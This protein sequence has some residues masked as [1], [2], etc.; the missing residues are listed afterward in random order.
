MPRLH[1]VER[2][3][4]DAIA[5]ACP[6]VYRRWF[7][8]W[9]DCDRQRRENVASKDYAPR[10]RERC[11]AWYIMSDA[12][13]ESGFLHL[14]SLMRTM[15]TV[16]PML[17]R[18]TMHQREV[19]RQEQLAPRNSRGRRTGQTIGSYVPNAFD[20]A[21][22][23]RDRACIEM[24]DVLLTRPRLLMA[25]V[26]LTERR[27]VSAG[28]APLTEYT[29]YKYVSY[30]RGTIGTWNAMPL[31][32]L[33][34][35]RAYETN[36]RD[37]RVPITVKCINGCEYAGTYYFTAGDYCRL[38]MIQRDKSRV[39][40]GLWDF[41]CPMLKDGNPVQFPDEITTAPEQPIAALQ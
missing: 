12:L 37:G 13:D 11:Y 25:Y 30:K 40:Q 17:M 21:F 41:D 19:R 38:K 34:S 32:T 35:G 27:P 14:A 10:Y 26:R 24:F 22:T 8:G 23:N 2:Q 20:R 15:P 3:L 31:G 9:I 39:D 36:L 7:Q 4:A 29:S 16:M 5:V 6:S 28:P 1:Q 33:Y 18:W